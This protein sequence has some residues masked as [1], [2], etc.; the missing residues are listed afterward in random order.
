MSSS[1]PKITHLTHLDRDVE[2]FSIA[3]DKR[4][5]FY[6]T[7]GYIYNSNQVSKKASMLNI[8]SLEQKELPDLNQARSTHTSLILNGLLFVMGGRISGT[9]CSGSIECLSMAR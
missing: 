6:I 4:R 2:W 5:D 3:V 1:E 7:G 8:E 9:D